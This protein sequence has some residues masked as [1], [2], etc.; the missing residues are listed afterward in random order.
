MFHLTKTSSGPLPLICYSVSSSS[1]VPLS[2]ISLTGTV[3]MRQR[4]RSEAEVLH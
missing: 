3:R 4:F 2:L 1:A